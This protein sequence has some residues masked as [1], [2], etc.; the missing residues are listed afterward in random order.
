MPGSAHCPMRL[1]ACAT[2]DRGVAQSHAPPHAHTGGTA[3]MPRRCSSSSTGSPSHEFVGSGRGHARPFPKWGTRS[4]ASILS[5]SHP[6][7]GSTVVYWAAW[8]RVPRLRN[9]E[10]NICMPDSPPLGLHSVP[11]YPPR[12]GTTWCHSAPHSETWSQSMLHHTFRCLTLGAHPF[13]YSPTN[14]LE[15]GGPG[16]KPR[17]PTTYKNWASSMARL[18]QT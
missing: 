2:R 7:T 8:V 18:S 14:P 10:R 5:I 3:N 16:R 4:R 13:R 6:R 17:L 9:K 15:P 1:A 11:S 12:L